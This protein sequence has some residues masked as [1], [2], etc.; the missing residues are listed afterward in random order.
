MFFLFLLV[1]F[2]SILRSNKVHFRYRFGVPKSIDFG[3]IWDPFWVH[4]GVHL[5]DPYF[6]ILIIKPV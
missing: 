5:G 3:P 6:S 1:Q 4:V 2:G